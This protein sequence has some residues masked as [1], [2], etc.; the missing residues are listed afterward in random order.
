MRAR[1]IPHAQWHLFFTDFTELYHGRHVN[2]ESMGSDRARIGGVVSRVRDKPLAGIVL[3][4]SHA[5]EPDDGPV[6]WVEV[7]AGQTPYGHT[8]CSITHPQRV[9]IGEEGR[10]QVVALQIESSDGEVTIIRFEPPLENMP[11]G[12][13]V[14]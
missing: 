1:E 10:G 12:F 5:T 4:E 11:P 3:A 14:C 2:V 13:K 6:E 9:M 7:I 8:T